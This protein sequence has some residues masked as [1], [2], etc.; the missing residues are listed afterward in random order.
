MIRLILV[1]H[2]LTQWNEEKRYLGDSDI[3]LNQNGKQQAVALMHALKKE[4]FDQIFASNLKRAFET[5]TIIK[6]D[7]EVSLISDVR[8]RELNLGALEGLTF[9]EAKIKYPDMLSTW[10]ENYDKPPD[11]GELFSSLAERV[12]SFLDDLKMIKAHK[13]ILIVAHGGT[14]R[15]I[16]RLLLGM[17]REKHWFSHF[18]FASLSE[19]HLFD[20]QPLIV[21]INDTHHL[22][23][24]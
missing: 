1:R 24:V 22:R 19:V 18:D 8:L 23:E 14:L 5:A 11:G 20:D 13:T 17:P 9:L 4:R 15:E 12:S 16:I 7:R 6:N 3:P 2:G 10:L 21:R